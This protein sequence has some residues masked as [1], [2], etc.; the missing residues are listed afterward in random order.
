MTTSADGGGE[1]GAVEQLRVLASRGHETLLLT[2]RPG[3]AESAGVA[4]RKIDLGPKLSRASW[5]AVVA[6][7]RAYR[8]RLERALRDELA[9]DV[10]LVHYKKEQLLAAGLPR[11]LRPC[12][13]WAE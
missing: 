8:R 3:L 7:W 4:T 5:P 6:R 13:V 2:N 11:E 12:L 9:Y 1:F 10:L